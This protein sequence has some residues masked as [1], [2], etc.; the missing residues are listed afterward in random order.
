MKWLHK[1]NSKHVTYKPPVRNFCAK[2]KHSLS[3]QKPPKVG[4]EADSAWQHFASRKP[5]R[6]FI[7]E[8]GR[9]QYHWHTQKQRADWCGERRKC[10]GDASQQNGNGNTSVS[11]SDAAGDF[12][13]QLAKRWANSNTNSKATATPA[14]KATATATATER[15]WNIT[16][17]V[18]VAPQSGPTAA[19]HLLLTPYC[20]TSNQVIITV[21]SKFSV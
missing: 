21:L 11:A 16:K 12:L 2:G 10:N 5:K 14:A 13:A 3:R 20:Q 7:E 4:A 9:K 8:H 17:L 18:R 15:Q 19:L 6:S 1:V